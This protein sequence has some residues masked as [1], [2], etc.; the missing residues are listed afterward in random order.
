[1][2]YSSFI[3]MPGDLRR[4][5]A[6]LR[7]QARHSVN[8]RQI[9]PIWRLLRLTPRA[10]LRTI[11]GET[12]SVLATLAQLPQALSADDPA[13]A[14]VCIV[15]AGPAGLTLAA[16][17]AGSGRRVLL[18]EA[19]GADE[20][21][22]G[23]DA[24]GGEVADPS[25]HWP[26]DAYRVRALGGTSRIWGGRAI[27]Y[28][29]ID[30]AQRDWVPHSGWPIG[31][32]AL[33]PYWAPALA[34]AEAGAA[35]YRPAGPLIP[36]LDGPTFATTIE[37]FS[38][39]T[40]FW[41]RYGPLLAA[42]D[43]CV[44]SN[45]P[46]TAVRLAADGARVDHLEVREGGAV[47]T[48]R[49][50]N[51]VLAMG[52]LETT[53]LLLA[54]DD[55]CPAGI[56]NQ[57]GWLGRNYMCHL[58]G[59]FGEVR[60]TGDPRKIAYGYERDA[61]GIYMRRRL[62]LTEQ[63]QRAH[64]LLNFTA[65]LHIPD[66]NNPAHGNAVLSMIFLAARLVKYEYSRSMREGDRS[67]P[68]LARHIAN[69]ARDPLA[70]AHFASTWGAKRYLSSRRIPSIALYAR[71]GRY[72]IEFHCEQAPNPDSRVTLTD[73]RDALGMRRLRVD[74][75][76]TPLDVEAVR[77]AYHLLGDELVRTGT[78][79]LVWDEHSV[80]AAILSAGAYGG[81]HSGTARMAADPALGVVDE[82]CRV[83]GVANLYLA[84]GAVL[85]TSSQANPTLAILALAL[86]LGDHLLK[87][88]A[89]LVP[90]GRRVLVTGAGGFIGRAVVARL[91]AAG[92]SVRAATRDGR[93]LPDAESWRCDCRDAAAVAAAMAGAAAVVHCAVGADPAEIPAAM[94]N[95]LAAAQTVGAH[96]VQMSS[97]AVYGGRNMPR[98]IDETAPTTRPHGAYGRAKRAAEALCRA[99]SDAGT[100]VTL[101]RPALVWGAGSRDWTQRP[102]DAMRSGCWHTPQG[103]ANGRANLVHVD[104]VAGFVAHVL[105]TPPPRALAVFNVVGPEAPAW[106]AYLAGLQS[107]FDLPPALPPRR[108]PRLALAGRLA[109]RIATRRAAGL[110]RALRLWASAVPSRDEMQ[111]FADPTIVAGDRMRAAGYMPQ[112]DLAEGLARLAHAQID[113]PRTPRPAPAGA[114]RLEIA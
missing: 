24:Y 105:S 49:A 6:A 102:I 89:P 84:S 43:V 71:D 35:N 42:S 55:V 40:D 79:R 5:W 100:A 13:L 109:V 111:R 61:E 106:A 19:G 110:P 76:I 54:S 41:T 67:W 27:P 58:A 38:R 70:L 75:R 22:A 95:V 2:F 78:G 10:Y 68:V 65:R 93:A 98:M 53:R 66:A 37:R 85:P 107:T 97:V 64:R 28:D 88:P 82:A 16:R 56:G 94:A 26:L 11:A 46:V 87:P 114:H 59:S 45:A 48:I 12:R 63:A 7:S 39:P 96:V 34:A 9:Q 52:G 51:Y 4:L 36:G 104:D 29:P 1:M 57:S 99:A 80:E 74:W 47:R 91:A 90:A 103:A 21:A 86:R 101:L 50:R 30:F 18:L 62:A 73:A 113:A 60:L 31:P 23:R 8:L 112:I 44:V 3:Y 32:E 69:I 17:L 92:F 81:H 25:L 77:G 72:P 14:D 15:G 83:H 20:T 108:W 33:A